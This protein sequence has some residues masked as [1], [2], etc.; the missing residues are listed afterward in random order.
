MTKQGAI[1]ARMTSP[2][3]FVADVNNF[4]IMES[5]GRREAAQLH[6]IRQDVKSGSAE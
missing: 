5:R 4:S 1:K 6:H 3:V 2:D